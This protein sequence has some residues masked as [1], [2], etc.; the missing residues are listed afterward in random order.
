MVIGVLKQPFWGHVVKTNNMPALMIYGRGI[1]APLRGMRENPDEGAMR[2]LFGGESKYSEALT[3]K[4]GEEGIVKAIQK[5][6]DL[7]H[8]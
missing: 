2:K 8:P 5:G 1:I 4:W 6:V 3:M 7:L